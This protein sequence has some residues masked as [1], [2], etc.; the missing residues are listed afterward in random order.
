MA[1]KT[2]C[3]RFDVR[4]AIEF[5]NKEPF[6]S[7]GSVMKPPDINAFIAAGM[8]ALGVKDGNILGGARFGMNLYFPRPE[9]A[10]EPIVKPKKGR[11]TK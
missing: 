8:K 9:P 11:R 2:K 6:D 4:F 3:V 10:P 1:R 7:I 5:E